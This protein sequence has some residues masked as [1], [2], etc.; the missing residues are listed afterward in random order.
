MSTLKQSL[1]ALW[2]YPLPHHAL[3]RL[4]GKLTHCKVPWVKDLLIRLFVLKFDIDM[5]E[6]AVGGPAAYP[7]FNDFFT[8]PLKP[9]IRPIDE[10][11]G[12]IV[13]PVDGTISQ[14]GALTSQW[15]IQAKGRDYSAAALLGDPEL[16]S[17]FEDGEFTTL[18][19][20]PR[21]YHRIH[22]PVSGSLRR[23]I[24]I[25]GRLFSVNPATTEAVE[26]LFARNERVAC[27]FD[28]EA[29][30]MAMVLVGALL[31]ASIETV[32]HGV[33]TPP[34]RPALRS[35]HYP[36]GKVELGKGEEMGRFNMGSTV[37]LLFP[38]GAVEWLPRAPGDKL[39]LGSPVAKILTARETR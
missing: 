12:S 21:D 31:V 25:P 28:T 14:M 9:G 24:H 34:T 6:A 1:F 19:L 18:Y 22:M 30:P 35:W 27:L 26:N 4:V 32:W 29:G 5:G 13:S 37:I 10:E 20:S 3:S 23:M 38:Q 15:L 2:Q 7:S 36:P 33:V 39:K 11:P 17:R 8:R 16:A